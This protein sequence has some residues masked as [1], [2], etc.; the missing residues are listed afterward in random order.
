MFALPRQPKIE[1]VRF[2][3]GEYQRVSNAAKTLS[4][5]IAHMATVSLLES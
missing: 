1:S 4:G 3:K 5:H 2:V